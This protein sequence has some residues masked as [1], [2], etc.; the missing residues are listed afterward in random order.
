[1]EVRKIKKMWRNGD[2]VEEKGVLKKRGWKEV[3]VEKRKEKYDGTE[4]KKME[5]SSTAAN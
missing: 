5:E 4:E 1:M 3:F 2:G